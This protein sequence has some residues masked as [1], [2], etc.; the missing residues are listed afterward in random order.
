[1]PVNL[2]EKDTQR[3]LGTI[4]D[5]QLR[6]LVDELEEEAPTDTDYY[7]DLDTV[8]MLEEDGA[9][10]ALIHLLRQ[11]LDGRDGMDVRW[12]RA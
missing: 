11:M 3:P 4:S 10:P 9:D 6:F 12:E 8:D 5:A 2:F 7:L 1:M